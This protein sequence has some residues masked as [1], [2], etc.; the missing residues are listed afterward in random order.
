MRKSNLPGNLRFQLRP[1]DGG[2]GAGEG[3]TPSLPVPRPAND[4]T[5]E[6]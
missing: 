1:G 2:P 5:S 6:K 3:Q 4:A